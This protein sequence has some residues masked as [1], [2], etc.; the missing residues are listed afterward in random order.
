M[1]GSVL[2]GD[3]D[4][5]KTHWYCAKNLK[6]EF[7]WIKDKYLVPP[8]VN[9]MAEYITCGWDEKTQKPKSRDGTNVYTIDF[10]GLSAMKYVDHGVLGKH[11]IPDLI[12]LINKLEKEGYVE[13]VDLFGAPY[14]WR[15]NPHT[16]DD[17]YFPHLKE[18]IE[19]I[20]ADS[21]NQKITMYGISAGCMA[22]HNFLTMY[23]DQEWKDK[24]IKKILLH[25]PSY[26]GA[27]DALRV[28]WDRKVAFFPGVYNTESVRNMSETI[29]TL[30]GHMPNTHA[31]THLVYMIG[32]DGKE[33]YAKDLVQLIYDHGKLSDLSMPVFKAAIPF[34]DRDLLPTGV[35]T[36]FL[37]NSVLETPLGY[38]YKDGWDKDPV[39]LTT[40]GDATITKDSLYYACNTWKTNYPTICHDLMIND[41]KYS[42]SGQLQQDDVQ[43]IL[44]DAIKDDSWIVKG[45]HNITGNTIKQ[46]K[47]LRAK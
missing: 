17:I 21:G 24:Y 39:P 43:D 27:G 45:I 38:N 28:I 7:I 6:D 9:C 41:T 19:Q 37:F 12:H 4:D 5:L 22:I 26:G 13:R 33:Y 46:W 11:F 47:S 23:V 34:F 35:P 29:P 20:Y 10:G 32:P 8:L 25:G 40:I 31:N 44:Y 15:M 1:F 18:L 14:D 3:I 42:H 36:Y 16:L 2:H 30:H